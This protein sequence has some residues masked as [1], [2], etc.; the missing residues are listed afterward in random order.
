M[1]TAEQDYNDITRSLT[2]TKIKNSVF[3]KVLRNLL[4]LED[5]ELSAKK[6][7]P[8][9]I[10]GY[11][12]SGTEREES[13]KR[14]RL[15]FESLA[16]IPKYLVDTSARSQ[17]TSIFGKNYSSPFGV[18]P[19]GGISLGAYQGELIMARSSAKA[20]IPMILSGAALTTM[21]KVRENG[22]TT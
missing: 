6:Y 17:A 7:I 18:S 14:N 20:N 1:S 12:K 10:F 2:H 4:S 11:I 13:I 16:F 8:S 22:P 19:M 3:K 15:A 9:P 21:E 5:F